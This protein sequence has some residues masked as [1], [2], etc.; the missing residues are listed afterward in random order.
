MEGCLTRDPTVW[1]IMHVKNGTWH[2]HGEPYW[3][4]YLA[5]E[6]HYDEFARLDVNAWRGADEDLLKTAANEVRLM[7][8]CR[9]MLDALH[10][11]NMY[12]VVI[13]NGLMCVARR[14][15]E[16]CGIK[17]AHAN[18]AVVKDGKLTGELKLDVPF[19]EKGSILAKIMEE[20]NAEPRRVAAVGD[21]TGDLPMFATAAT[22]IAVNPKNRSVRE[23]ATHVIE[24]GNLIECKDIILSKL[25][26]ARF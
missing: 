15:V 25:K 23:A 1:E 20:T 4:S 24:S 13:S 9:E 16:E 12:T 8:G 17:T 10:E 14:L 5:G 7:P 3:K 18:R 22:S 19:G 6:L 2:S 26:H 21:D 11:M